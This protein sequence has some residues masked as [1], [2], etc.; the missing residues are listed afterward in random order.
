MPAW[1]LSPLST[2]DLTTSGTPAP[3]LRDSAQA[4]LSILRSSLR[5]QGARAARPLWAPGQHQAWPSANSMLGAQVQQHWSRQDAHC[6]RHN[7]TIHPVEGPRQPAPLLPVQDTASPPPPLG[8]RGCDGGSRCQQL[9]KKSSSGQGSGVGCQGMVTDG[10][11]F[12][13]IMMKHSREEE[14]P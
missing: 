1:A 2:Q 5:Y 11:R 12:F 13:I 6:P 3:Q 8:T 4:S 7:K 14:R 9:D 10:H